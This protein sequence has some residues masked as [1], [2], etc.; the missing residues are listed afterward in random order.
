MAFQRQTATSVALSSIGPGVRFCR[1]VYR[2]Y[3]VTFRSNPSGEAPLQDEK[4]TR[5]VSICSAALYI[6]ILR[7]DYTRTPSAPSLSQLR[8]T[9][10]VSATC[11]FTSHL[12]TIL[13]SLTCRLCSRNVKVGKS[14]RALVSG[15]VHKLPRTEARGLPSNPI[16]IAGKS[17]CFSSW[18]I[19]QISTE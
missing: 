19:V 9:S 6:Q 5:V 15:C 1:G 3:R 13:H 4:V 14:L 16:E 18:E 10:S 8:P 17:A 7:H 2:R 12:A 11:H